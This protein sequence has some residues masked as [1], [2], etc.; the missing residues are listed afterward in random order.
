MLPAA[1]NR[2]AT[3]DSRVPSWAGPG[4]L[5]V[6]A[7][8]IVSGVS[9][10][11][12]AYAVQ[13]TNSDAFVTVRNLAV[14]A[15]LIPIVVLGRRG[16]RD[17]LRRLDWGRL[18]II[19]LIGGAIPFLLFFRGLSLATAHGGAATA[20]FGY[21]TLFLMAGVLAVVAL[22]ER[23]NARWF[24]AAA[25]LLIGN[26]L[27]VALT[28]PIW[29][30]GTVYVLAATGLWAA[31]Y[32]LSKRT[33]KDLPS[34]VVGLGRMGFGA[35]FLVGYLI[36]SGQAP[37]MT[38]ISA[39]QWTWVALSAILLTAFVVSWYAGLK[40]VDLGTATSALVLGFP[41]TWALSLLIRGGPLQLPQAVG[42]VLVVLGA[43]TVIG[44]TAL[45]ESAGYLSTLL[46]GPEPSTE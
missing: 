26:A 45:R 21:R 34:S 3:Q 11:L 41:I 9:T 24:A 8:A 17:R 7:T 39:A 4:V 37:S 13:G 16:I 29:T 2:V 46:R 22:G 33:L 32:T 38:S 35:L 42:A 43:I 40:R 14:A 28:S 44:F 20:S 15:M 25:L 31:E 23:L 36:A 1:G 19:G 12:N 5:L 27:L 18:A 30:D 6:L 10:F